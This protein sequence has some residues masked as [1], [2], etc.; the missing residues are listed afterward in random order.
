M[1]IF[2]HLLS[3]HI[4]ES[5]MTIIPIE[6]TQEDQRSLF[7]EIFEHAQ[8]GG[9]LSY[10]GVVRTVRRMW[11][12]DRFRTVFGAAAQGNCQPVQ[13]LSLARRLCDRRILEDDFDA[14]IELS[15]ME[16]SIEETAPLVEEAPLP[17]RNDRSVFGP[18]SDPGEGSCSRD[19]GE[20][21]ERPH[22]HQYEVGLGDRERVS[23]RRPR[24]RSKTA[25]EA[26]RR[27]QRS[28]FISRILVRM[29]IELRCSNEQ[30]EHP[31]EDLR[32]M[33]RKSCFRVKHG[34]GRRPSSLPRWT[35]WVRRG[36]AEVV[37]G[38]AQ[39]V[40]TVFSETKSCVAISRLLRSRA[41]R[42][43]F[44]LAGRDAEGLLAG[45]RWERRVCAGLP[46]DQHFL[47]HDRF[48]DG[49]AIARDPESEPDAEGREEDGDQRA[50]ELDGVLDD[51]KAV[52]GVLE[53]GDKEAAD[54][55]EDEG[56]ALHEGVVKKYIPA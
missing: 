22:P 56:V 46:R 4:S 40:L 15:L 29:R 5:Y 16:R 44:E 7:F 24:G 34:Q 25:R 33:A 30:D 1:T 12:T 21:V 51:D 14:A 8:E 17:K 54:K 26:Y 27:A 20:D 50:V 53:G 55:T 10:N 19:E 11:N 49:L 47:H 13:F 32:G 9:R 35:A 39:W 3:S 42:L 45:P 18:A 41:T 52:F 36:G 28:V 37:E 2:P 31:S 48:S 38:R 43:S 23:A 6:G